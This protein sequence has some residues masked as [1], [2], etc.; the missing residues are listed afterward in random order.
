MPV[1]VEKV[2]DKKTGKM[3][4]KLVGKDKKKQYYIRTYVADEFGNKHQITRHNKK[5]LGRDGERFAQ[6]EEIMIKNTFI[7]TEKETKK[8]ED[9]SITFKELFYLK[10]QNDELYHKNSQATR[11]SYEQRIVL[12][13]FPIFGEKVIYKLK[14]VDFDNLLKHLTK[15]IIQSGKNKGKNL[16]VEYINDI[17]LITKATIEFGIENYELNN[18]LLKFINTIQKNR[19]EIKKP[20]PLELMKKKTI[21]SPSDWNKV[22]KTMEKTIQ[23]CK[24]NKKYFLTKMML[25]LTTEYILLTRVGET[26]GMRY[27][28][29]LFDYSVYSLYDAWNKRT[30]TLTPTK[31][32]EDRILYIPD[33]LLNAFKRLYEIDS[34]RDNFDMDEFIFGT[35]KVFSRTTID[36]YREKLFKDSGVDYLTNH[37]LRHAGISNAMHEKVDASA[38]AD[39][40][41]HD[42]E[43]MYKTYVQTLKEANYELINSL[44]KLLVPNF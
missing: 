8:I 41:G 30:K 7:Y 33:S 19:D 34:K 38:V 16:K 24:A 27:S 1:Y 3:I 10:L 32:R 29:L 43:V 12:H 40:A 9:D 36:R 28:N 39:M 6:Q 4:D 31:N 23:E 17:L 25:F 26:Q 15:H 5:W 21:L 13:V 18:Q 37:E 42:K 14:K 44:D 20:D 35:D 22:A 11:I 2:K